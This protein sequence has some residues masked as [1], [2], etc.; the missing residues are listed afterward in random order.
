VATV[1]LGAWQSGGGHG[2]NMVGMGGRRCLDRAAN[3][4]A[5]AVSDFSNLSKNG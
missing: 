3:K 1:K 4:W 2:L 5:L